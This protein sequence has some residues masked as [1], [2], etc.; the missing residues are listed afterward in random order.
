M[1]IPCKWNVLSLS[2]TDYSHITWKH[3]LMWFSVFWDISTVY[4]PQVYEYK[5]QQPVQTV[6][7]QLRA[8]QYTQAWFDMAHVRLIF[9]CFNLQFSFR[10]IIENIFTIRHFCKIWIHKMFELQMWLDFGGKLLKL[11]NLSRAILWE[12]HCSYVFFFFSKSFTENVCNTE[13][14]SQVHT[15]CHLYAVTTVKTTQL[16]RLRKTWERR[17]SKE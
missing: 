8:W 15:T 3:T 9:F 17:V 4:K 2:F 5:R 12:Q 11:S 6:K 13:K 14:Q 10:N 16:Q 7:I 1:T